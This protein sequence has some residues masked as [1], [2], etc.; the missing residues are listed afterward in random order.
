MNDLLLDLFRDLLHL[1]VRA[2]LSLLVLHSK[3]FLGRSKNALLARST[4]RLTVLYGM[5][6]L[7]VRH[8]YSYER[9]M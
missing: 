6:C 8:L 2:T 9:Y 5:A 7:F 1:L 4:V 3:V